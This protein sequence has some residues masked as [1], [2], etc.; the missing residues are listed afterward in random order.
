MRLADKVLLHQVHPA[1]IAA[2]VTASEVSNLLLWKAH[3]KAGS[4]WCGRH[5][6]RLVACGVAANIRPIAGRPAWARRL[7]CVPSRGLAL[8]QRL[9]SAWT[10]HAIK[11]SSELAMFRWPPGTGSGYGRLRLD[12]RGPGGLGK[13]S[14]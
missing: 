3:P 8:I 11:E 1:K 6:G 14:G 2:D 9:G 13:G 12:E 4:S 5:R 10:Y 7:G